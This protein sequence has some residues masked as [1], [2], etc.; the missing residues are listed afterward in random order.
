MLT[1]VRR[2]ASRAVYG[3]EN[4]GVDANATE[5]IERTD[6]KRT[7]TV[8]AGGSERSASAPAP[9]LCVCVFLVLLPVAMSSPCSV[10]P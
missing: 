2:I 7:A 8:L 6:D 4:D 10:Y 9:T 1:T 5:L 3:D